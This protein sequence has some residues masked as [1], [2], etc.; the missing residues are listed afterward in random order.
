MKNF[1][2]NIRRIIGDETDDG[3]F[4]KVNTVDIETGQPVVLDVPNFLKKEQD[5]TFP[6]PKIVL[7]AYI[8][9]L[10]IDDYEDEDN[11]AKVT[12]HEGRIQID[13]EAKDYLQC[14][15]IANAVV[16]RFD[17]FFTD[18]DLL[19]FKDPYEWVDYEGIKQNLGYDDNRYIMK[20]GDYTRVGSIEEVKATPNTWCLDSTGI[21]VNG[22]TDL[23]FIESTEKYGFFPNG[24]TAYERGFK[25]AD[26]NIPLRE[27][28]GEEEDTYIF[29]VEY[30]LTYE[31]SRPK[32]YGEPVDEI[33][34]TGSVN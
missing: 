28:P 31:I 4:T 11:N 19:T 9:F 24:E 32:N 21:Y 22:E 23:T 7:E 1:V 33:N 5:N 16:G 29:T 26:K 13:V 6:G 27:V 34:I 12:V 2:I 20:Y 17:S 14:I 3:F 18:L 10:P 30:D 15:D 25:N 8:S